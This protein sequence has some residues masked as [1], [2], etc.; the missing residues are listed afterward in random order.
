MLNIII[1]ALTFDSIDNCFKC[2]ISKRSIL[3]RKVSVN[4]QKICNQNVS[5]SIL[6][7]QDN[8]LYDNITFDT[9][10]EQI[11]VNIKQLGELKVLIVPNTFQFSFNKPNGLST[12]IAIITFIIASAAIV[13]ALALNKPQNSQNLTRRTITQLVIDDF[14][15]N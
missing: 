2:R 4:I 5:A 14:Q 8:K 11:S 7:F 3:N 10:E 1:S 13:I 12:R 15:S 9:K 6:V